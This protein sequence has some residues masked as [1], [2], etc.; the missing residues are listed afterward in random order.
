MRLLLAAMSVIGS[1]SGPVCK[2]HINTDGS[3][4]EADG[5]TE[6]EA[7]WAFVVFLEQMQGRTTASTGLLR[8]R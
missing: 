7:A 4:K 3:F 1:P 8:D 2:V 6:T 5:E